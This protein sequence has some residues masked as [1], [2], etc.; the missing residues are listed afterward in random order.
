LVF[1]LLHPNVAVVLLF[2]DGA[3]CFSCF[4]RMLQ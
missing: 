1:D 3:V 2:W 4:N